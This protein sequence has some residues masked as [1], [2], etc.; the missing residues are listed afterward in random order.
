M[1]SLLLM[2]T[3]CANVHAGTEGSDDLGGDEW[4]AATTILKVDIFDADV[5]TFTWEGSGPV[6]VFD[7][8]GLLLGSYPSGSTVDPIS[9]SEGTFEVHPSEDQL[10]SWRITVNNQ[11]IAGGRV[12]TDKWVIE[13]G[14]DSVVAAVDYNLWARVPMGASTVE[15]IVEIQVSGWDAASCALMASGIGSSRGEGR[16]AEKPHPFDPEYELYLN[17][18]VDVNFGQITPVATAA[19]F[20]AGTLDCN[21]LAPTANEGTFRFDSNVDGTYHL[22]C[23]LNRDGVLD[24]TNNSDYLQVGRVTTGSNTV[25]WDGFD[26]DGLDYTP[27]LVD[28]EL[29]LHV[30]ETHFVANDVE[31]SYEGVQMYVWDSPNNFNPTYMLWNDTD[32]F[33]LSQAMLN[34]EDGLMTSGEPGVWSGPIGSPILPNVNARSWGN[35]T[36]ASR[37]ADAYLDTFIWTLETQ[38]QAVS[39]LLVAPDLDTDDDRLYDWEEDC[40]YGTDEYLYDTDNDGLGDGSE[41]LDFISDPL[42]E[43][44]DGDTVIDG[45]EAGPNE[46]PIDFDGDGILDVNDTDDDDDT[47][48]TADEGGIDQDTDGDGSPDSRDVDDDGDGLL[49]TEENPPEQ[50]SDGDGIFDYLDPD[51]DNDTLLTIDEGRE[52]WDGDSF[53]DYIDPDDDGDTIPTSEE[54]RPDI[55]LDVDGDGEPNWHDLDADGDGWEDEVEGTGDSDEDGIPN[56]LDPDSNQYKEYYQGGCASSAAPLSTSLVAW[57]VLFGGIFRRRER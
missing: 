57:L 32:I 35:F 33:Y 24:R 42:N 21:T 8:S 37:G 17:R 48:P 12:H 29:W 27:G 49:T 10:V 20:S 5:E 22:I 36:N 38:V 44:T 50:D 41:V 39:I 6:E 19:S 14:A 31:T 1:M 30:G 51:D 47:V 28:C 16:S 15:Q 4:I 9:G 55:G 11:T 13:G 34:G 52:D 26:R 25:T 18:P 3:L 40:E 46:T 53:E 43:D 54:N 56:F 23:D 45:D 7:P 2:L